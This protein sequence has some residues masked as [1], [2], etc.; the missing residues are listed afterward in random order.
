MNVRPSASDVFLHTFAEMG[1]NHLYT[2]RRHTCRGCRGRGE[3]HNCYNG[4]VDYERELVRAI[5]EQIRKSELMFKY[6]KEALFNHV[7]LTDAIP[8]MSKDPMSRLQFDCDF[9]DQARLH[10]FSIQFLTESQFRRTRDICFM[11]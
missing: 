7:M 11:Q 2:A 3:E 5:A 8:F 10:L 1:F 9:I 6:A 4:N